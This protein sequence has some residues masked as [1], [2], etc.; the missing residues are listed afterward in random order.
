MS[1]ISVFKIQFS[2]ISIALTGASFVGLLWFFPSKSDFVKQPPARTI[3]KNSYPKS[4][5][6][7]EPKD[8]SDEGVFLKIQKIN[9]INIPQKESFWSVTSLPI[10]KE[11]FGST[12]PLQGLGDSNLHLKTETLEVF[13]TVDRNAQTVGRNNFLNNQL[14][15]FAVRQSSGEL[16]KLN[17]NYKINSILS[18]NVRTNNLD[19][20][21]FDDRIRV[22]PSTMAGFTLKG[23]KYVTAGFLTGETRAGSMRYWNQSGALGA[24]S[25]EQE[26]REQGERRNI[27]EFQTNI[28]ATKNIGIQTAIYNTNRASLNEL[29]PTEGA[30]VSMFMGFDSFMLNLRYNYSGNDLFRGIRPNESF[31][32]SRDYAGVGVTFFFDRFKNYSLFLGNN[33]HNLFNQNR[34]E[35]NDQRTLPAVSS[36]SASLRGVTPGSNAL[37]FFNFRNQVSKDTQYTNFGMMRLPTQNLFLFEYATA[38]GMELSF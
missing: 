38:L 24:L 8:E 37:F 4:S 15:P 29:G 5:P 17:L 31:S 13:G 30:R 3:E 11:E 26:V 21:L 2:L 14:D 28:H 36:F 20:S 18:A 12:D 1:S 33:Y 10:L 9:S 25:R 19:N 23:S 32:Y 6:S 35:T 27:F 22:A 7:K 34:Y 16:R